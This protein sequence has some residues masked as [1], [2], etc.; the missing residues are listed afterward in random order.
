M[1]GNRSRPD[2]SVELGVGLA[3][4]ARGD[5]PCGERGKSRLSPDF[6]GKTHAGAQSGPVFLGCEKIQTDADGNSRVRGG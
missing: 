1:K 6:A 4:R 3:I 2:M 5:L